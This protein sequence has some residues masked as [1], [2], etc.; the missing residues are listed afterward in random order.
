L[1]VLSFNKIT[2]KL[3][4]VCTVL[5][6]KFLEG[7]SSNFIIRPFAYTATKTIE[8]KIEHFGAARLYY[9]NKASHRGRAKK[10]KPPILAGGFYVKTL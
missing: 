4:F 5:I 7:K 9:T 1:L 3:L 8:R 10:E 6:L 2:V